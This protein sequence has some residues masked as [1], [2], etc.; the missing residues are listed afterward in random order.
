VCQGVL[1][2]NRS[3]LKRFSENLRRE[4]GKKLQRNNRLQK[5]K[6]GALLG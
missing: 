1:G 3:D 5:K 4:N 2:S 6:Q